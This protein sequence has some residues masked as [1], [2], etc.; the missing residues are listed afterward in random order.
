MANSKKHVWIV[1]ASSGIGASLVALYAGQGWKVTASARS[2]DKLDALCA[3]H[4]DVRSLPLDV[5]QNEQV[6]QAVA[7]LVTGG[8]LPDL[9]IFCSGIYYPGG[10][11]VLNEENA[12]KSMDTNYLGAV[13]LLAALYPELKS[14]G[15]GHVALISSLS[16]YRGLPNAACY[17]PTKAAMISLCETMKPEFDRDGLV[18]SLV[19]PGFVK[20][21]MTD[22]NTFDM[23]FIIDADKA[24]QIIKGGLDKKTFEIIFPRRLAYI[25]KV[26]RMLPYVLFFP[27]SKLMAKR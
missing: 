10:M 25:L 21:P 11:K 6:T 5:T 20:T 19:N 17:G 26:L 22:V 13:R 8:A 4:E 7:D 9:T 27:L 18:L 12:A 2:A 1:G 3:A 15:R 16:G 24:A 23:P 14:W